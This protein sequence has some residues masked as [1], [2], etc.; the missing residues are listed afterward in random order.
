MGSSAVL[1]QVQDSDLVVLSKFGKLEAMRQGLFPVFEAA[2]ANGR[3]LLT[4][5]SGK[6]RDTWQA[7]APDAISIEADEAVL[8]QWWRERLKARH[9]AGDRC[10]R[11]SD[12]Q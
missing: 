3:P 5:V 7:F 9:G 10:P 2:I 8:T 12:S 11:K 1:N 6:H 4:T